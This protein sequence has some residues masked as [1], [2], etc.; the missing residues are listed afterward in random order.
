MHAAAVVVEVLAW[1]GCA[2]LL[3]APILLILSS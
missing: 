1:C 2:L 3:L